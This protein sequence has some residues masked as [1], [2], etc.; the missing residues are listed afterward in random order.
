MTEITCNHV[1]F[2]YSGFAN[3]EH[4]V[5]FERVKVAGKRVY[6]GFFTF[7]GSSG[8]NTISYS[9]PEGS[10]KVDARARWTTHGVTGDFDHAGKALCGPSI[11]IVK[12]QRIEGTKE[13]FTKELIVTEE[14]RRVEYKMTITNTG[15][16]PLELENF[17]DEHCDPGTI[18]DPPKVPLEP[19]ESITYTCSHLLVGGGVYTNQASIE[20][21]T[22]GGKTVSSES[23]V[24]VVETNA[25]PSFNIE[26]TQRI[27][28]EGPFVKHVIT[29][30]VGE[31]V[32]YNI[33]VTNT[34][35][36][37]LTFGELV[38]AHCDAGT[39]S[40]GPEGPL[41]PGESATYTCA[42]ALT[43]HNSYYEN[44]ATDTAYPPENEGIP[45]TKNSNCVVVNLPSKKRTTEEGG[46]EI[47]CHE[48]TFYFWGF[49]LGENT[50][51]ERISYGGSGRKVA[52][53]ETFTFEGPE[54]MNTV[55]FEVP[56]GT[57]VIDTNVSWD[58]GGFDHHWVGLCENEDR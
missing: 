52:K 15:N 4:N 35:N 20:G 51:T 38:D 36:T 39:I 3:A 26:K 8:S 45:I 29:G 49:P 5:V 12:E 24:V 2:K 56:E 30:H 25:R 7:N 13:P 43:V 11:A 57:T 1:T 50:V 22:E 37:S 31:W 9:S 47:N 53:E 34:G 17:E 44:C 41:A 16:Q 21:K 48:A 23:N 46:S 27:G 42:H 6:E 54:G 40:G 19:N 32:E 55:M 28:E 33:T 10:V 18:S 14:G 58:G